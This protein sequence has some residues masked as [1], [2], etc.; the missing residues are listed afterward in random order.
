MKFGF[1]RKM[2]K[3]SYQIAFC[4]ISYL[5]IRNEHK[6]GFKMSYNRKDFLDKK[7]FNIETLICRFFQR[8]SSKV[9][10]AQSKNKL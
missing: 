8:F 7:L 6:K 3:K 5:Y 4:S 10:V 9:G 1:S 2:L